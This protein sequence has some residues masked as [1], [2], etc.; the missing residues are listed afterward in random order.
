[1]PFV[2]IALFLQCI[3]SS[4]IH[5][6]VCCT[7]AF[8]KP[9]CIQLLVSAEKCQLII[10]QDEIFKYPLFLSVLKVMK[11]SQ[12]YYRFSGIPLL[13]HCNLLATVINSFSILKVM[14][15]EVCGGLCF[16]VNSKFSLLIFTVN[17]SYIHWFCQCHV[18][19]NHTGYTMLMS[20]IQ[21]AQ[22]MYIVVWRE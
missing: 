12:F 14:Q 13:K 15:S 10:N 4:C 1:M 5:L 2:T 8:F 19:C 18:P 16:M 7:Q 9:Q 17:H 22:E 11:T 21:H 3:I 20:K 6:Q